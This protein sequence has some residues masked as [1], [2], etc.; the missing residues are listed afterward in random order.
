MTAPEF[1]AANQG[2]GAAVRRKEDYRFLTGRGRFT[3][4]LQFPDQL[5]AAFVRSPYAHAE[6]RGIDA[7]GALASPGVIAVFSGGDLVRDGVGDLELDYTPHNFDGRPLIVPPRMPLAV[8]RSRYAGEPVA[9]VIAESPLG[10]K[11]AAELI[12]V[13]YDEL[14]CVIDLAQAGGEQAPVIWQDAPRNTW[15]EV[16]YGNR[17]DVDRAFAGAAH[18]V[19]LELVNNRVIG[20]PLEPRAAIAAFDPVTRRHTLYCSHQTPY[21]LR[22]QL[23]A[24]LR[25]PEQRLRVVCYDVG[26]GF[27][28]KGVTYPEEAALVWAAGKLRRA[29]KWR[30]DRSEAFLS[31]AH[32]R[33]HVTR[34][35]MAC[36]AEGRFLAIRIRDIANL[37]AYV[38]SYGAGPPIIAQ[39]LLSAGPYRTG[40]VAGEVRLIFTNTV[41]TDA[42]RGAGRP[43]TTYMIERLVDC[44]AHE[45]KIPP[46]ELRRRNLIAPQ[47]LPWKSPLGRVYDSGD[48][49]K[50]LEMALAAA[51]YA[52]FEDRRREAKARGRLRGIGLSTYLEHSGMGPSDVIMAR[53]SRF[54]AYE[55]AQVRLNASGGVTVLTGTH[56]H[57]QGHETALAQLV[58]HRLG[59]ALDD[60]E[61]RHGDTDELGNGRGTVGSRSLLSGGAAIEVALDKIEAKGKAI[62]AHMLECSAGD[63]ELRRGR[64]TVSGTDRAV[65]IGEVAKAAYYPARFPL[66]Q[67]E[68]GL[69]EGGYW[70]PKAVALPNGCHVCEVEIDPATGTLYIVRVATVDDFGTIVNPM[71]VEGQVHG[72]LAQGLG[73][74][75]LERCLYDSEN[76]QL[77]SGSFMD[78][79]LPRAD[80]LPSFDTGT[81]CHRC[82][83]NPLGVK[84]CGE[85]GTIGSPPALVNAV[86]DALRN[87]GLRHADMPLTPEKLW[88]LASGGS[89]QDR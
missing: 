13:T 72:G 22:E 33:D 46:V 84:G 23:C 18:A 7:S 35:E 5:Y 76:G 43:E 57:G 4:D 78:Y 80:D 34:L 15:C 64:F 63:I 85:S 21:A 8:G 45:L 81:N 68:P 83:S 19:S 42:Y 77:L 32:A 2:I 59:I 1:E 86:M 31:D 71:I 37:G 88:R 73:Q 62:A 47:E 89:R 30:C 75:A 17:A 58:A 24:T 52:E 6:I 51:G 25:L 82:E 36:D 16:H 61:V 14:P 67:L 87:A 65:T 55:S 74:A 38:S 56:S 41:P 44:V 11:D 28:V 12:D 39:S 26:G 79:C 48:F 69:D 53:G 10:A 27:G 50:N 66:A 70:D 9:L 20:S 49:P 3:D 60:I 29:L 54:G 40:A